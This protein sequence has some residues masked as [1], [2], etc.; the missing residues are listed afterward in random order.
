L[1]LAFVSMV[2]ARDETLVSEIM[3]LVTAAAT[4]LAA[5]LAIR[6]EADFVGATIAITVAAVFIGLASFAL[7]GTLDADSVDGIRFMPDVANKNGFS[8]YA[9]PAILLS[10]YALVSLRLTMPMRVLI[11]VFSGTLVVALFMTANRSGWL[12]VFL[13]V[14]MLTVHRFRLR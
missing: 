6:C 1:V 4:T 2:S 10:G 5:T 8:L 3:K 11:G 14:V 9:L 12:G 7:G 13:I